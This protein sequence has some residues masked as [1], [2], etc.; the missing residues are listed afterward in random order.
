MDWVYIVLIVVVVAFIFVA[1]SKG[2]RGL[3]RENLFRQKHSLFTRAERSFLGV[4]DQA[5]EGQY[6]VFG[7]VRVADVLSTAKGLDKSTR[8]SA[9]NQIKAKHFDFV[10]CDPN[11]LD[12]KA[13]VELNDKSHNNRQRVER[14]KFLRMACRS[15]GLPLKEIQARRSYSV[16]SIR[17]VLSEISIEVGGETEGGNG[18]RIEPRF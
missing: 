5:T 17:Q 4:L 18:E 15:A 10:L 11:T 3:K 7:K 16:E 9:F 1:A 2:T 13:V 12:I 8:A 14:D 6:R